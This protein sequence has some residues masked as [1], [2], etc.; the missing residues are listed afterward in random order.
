MSEVVRR[1]IYFYRDKKTEIQRNR[2]NK[3]D[4]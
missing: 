2:W 4:Y 3:R 1:T